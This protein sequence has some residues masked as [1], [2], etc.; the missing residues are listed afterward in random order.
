MDFPPPKPKGDQPQGGDK[1]PCNNVHH[2]HLLNALIE[3][4]PL[5]RGVVTEQEEAWMLY[6]ILK[7]LGEMAIPR[8]MLAKFMNQIDAPG[9]ET[10]LLR[11]YVSNKPILTIRV[12]P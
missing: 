7:D 4:N 6:T 12:I 9:C 11:I 3:I 8:Q 1:P 5:P 10:F 2:T